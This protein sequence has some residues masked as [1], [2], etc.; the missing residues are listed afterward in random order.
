MKQKNFEETKKFKK[1]K[2]GED[3]VR[4]I[5]QSKGW[6]TY[7]PDISGPHY[8][9]ILAIKDK[10]KVIAIDVKTKARF[11]NYPAQGIDLRHYEEYLRFI[12]T[13]SIPFYLIFVDDKNGD[14]HVAK[15]DDLKDP[16]YPAKHIIAWGLYQMKK[17]A[18]IQDVKFFEEMAKLDERSY[19]YNPRN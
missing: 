8:F 5:L 17:I 1:G 13:C 3:I 14:I 7:S 11:N 6:V 16:F 4:G 12:N 15:L 9:D 2:I 10:E 19:K 18:T